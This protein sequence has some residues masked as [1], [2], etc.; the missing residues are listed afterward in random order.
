MQNKNHP[1][2]IT[3]VHNGKW[4]ANG[5]ERVEKRENKKVTPMPSTRKMGGKKI[6]TNSIPLI[7]ETLNKKIYT[8]HPETTPANAIAIPTAM[9][10]LEDPLETGAR[11]FVV[12]ALGLVVVGVEGPV[13]FPVAM[14]PAPRV[15]VERV[16]V[17]PDGDEDGGEDG[18]GDFRVVSVLVLVGLG[19]EDPFGVGSLLLVGEA[20]RP[21]LDGE[22]KDDEPEE[23]EEPDDGGTDEDEEDGKLGVPGLV[24]PPIMLPPLD[25]IEAEDPDLSE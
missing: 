20:M 13:E 16:S 7:K 25:L 2:C 1:L 15:T 18:E 23:S 8:S 19:L 11:V 17:E 6:K 24:P 14:K 10:V 5:P 12:C 3:F 9:V 21:L 4:N 22:L